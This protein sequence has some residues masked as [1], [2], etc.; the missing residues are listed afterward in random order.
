MPDMKDL[1][2]DL[3]YVFLKCDGDVTADSYTAYVDTQGYNGVE[4]V[5]IASA[6]TADSSNYITPKVYGTNNA[7]PGT[8]ANYTI[9]AAGELEGSFAAINSTDDYCDSV[10]LKQHLYRYY[11]VFLDETSTADADIAVVAILSA[12]H[13][14]A[15]DDS[16]TTGAVS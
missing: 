11:T 2:N 5:V 7:T 14:P 9:C 6:N 12:R 1:H 10:G 15:N 3:A 13:Q 8:F 4:F 16:V